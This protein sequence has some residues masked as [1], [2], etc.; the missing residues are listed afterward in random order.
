LDLQAD[1]PIKIKQLV[2]QHVS[3]QAGN[4]VG[5]QNILPSRLFTEDASPRFPPGSGDE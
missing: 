2:Q 3:H 4:F 1:H 5:I